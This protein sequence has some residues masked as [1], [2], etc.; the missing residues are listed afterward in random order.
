MSFNESIIEEAALGWF[1][2]LGY[3][4]LPDTPIAHGNPAAE[5]ETLGEGELE[6]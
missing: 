4:V 5:C 1:E 3:A 2:Q 6:W